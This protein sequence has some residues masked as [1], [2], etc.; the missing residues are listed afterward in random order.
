MLQEV[1]DGDLSHGALG[2][3]VP[4]FSLRLEHLNW[5]HLA[6]VAPRSV[7]CCYVST[8]LSQGICGKQVD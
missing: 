5:A 1:S 7:T 6:A 2:L 3:S 4:P 8:P